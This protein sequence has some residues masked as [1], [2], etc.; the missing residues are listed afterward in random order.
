[1]EEITRALDI[2]PTYT[3][4]QRIPNLVGAPRI[5]QRNWAFEFFP[6]SDISTEQAIAL[7]LAKFHPSRKAI[8]Q[9]LDKY[10][11][12][13]TIY[14]PVYVTNHC[15]TPFEFEGYEPVIEVS[16]D[17]MRQICEIGA[18]FQSS[19]FSIDAFES[20][21]N[22]KIISHFVDDNGNNN[23]I[24]DS[25]KFERESHLDKWLQGK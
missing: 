15:E 25:S 18:S 13:A 14:I 7:V 23:W 21:E 8:N 16:R 2:F 1:M 10:S 9:L 24:L 19:I 3:W 11:I 22:R 12:D 17:M 4:K 5:P 20:I 6:H